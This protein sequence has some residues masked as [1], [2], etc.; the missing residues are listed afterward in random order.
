[1]RHL[2]DHPRRSTTAWTT[3]ILTD[4]TLVTPRISTDLDRLP[5]LVGTT[6]GPTRWRDITQSAVDAFARLTGDDRWCFTDAA[7][8]L[9]SPFAGTIAPPLMVTAMVPSLLDELLEIQDAAL[10]VE[11][12]VQTATFPHLVP[13]GSAVQATAVVTAVSEVPGGIR[14]TIEVTVIRDGGL[15]PVCAIAVTRLHYR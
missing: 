14:C 9:Q 6:L 15:G 1:M 13:V 7:A 3:P 10:S 2:G 12:G 5:A 11:E 4:W 8:A